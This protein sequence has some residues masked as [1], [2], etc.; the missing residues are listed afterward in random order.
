MGS[1]KAL[2]EFQGETFLDRLIGMFAPYCS[3]I[4]AVLG[5][6][7]DVIRSGLRRAP[8]AMLV[9]NPDYAQGQLTSMQCGLRALP[10]GPEGVLFTLVDH[11]NPH[12]STVERLLTFPD[13]RAPV[14]RIP[15]Y[16]GKR[17]HPICFAPEL[18]PEFL[19]LPADAAARDVVNR[20]ATD[21]DYVDVDD[22][23]ILQDIDDRKAYTDLLQGK[24]V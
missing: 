1:P 11:P 10:A 2:L 16:R 15:R 6:S 18:I 8:Q 19:A 4:I 17:G 7:A 23:G 9:V 21:I 13:G 5:A 12:P 14:L 20:H 22:P 3:P 24:Q